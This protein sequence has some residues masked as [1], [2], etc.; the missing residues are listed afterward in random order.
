M[1][2]IAI[3]LHQRDDTFGQ[4]PYLLWP[5]LA[6]WQ[7][8][9]FRVLMLQG[10]QHAVPADLL[11][12]HLDLTVTPPDYAALYPRYPRVVNRPVLDIAKSAFSAQ[13]LR[14]GDAYD[15]PVIVK[16]DGN[17]GG[18]PDKHLGAGD[19]RPLASR[20]MKP[21]VKLRQR[22]G[23]ST[24]WRHLEHLPTGD[25]PVFQSLD[26]VPQGVFDNPRLVVE[27]FLAERDG[28]DYCLR[29]Y[30]FLGD[31]ESSLLLRSRNP[32]AKGANIDRVEPCPVPEELR[33][34][35]RRMGFD[36]GKFDYVLRDGR[37]VLF[38]V[39][40]TPTVT[41]LRRFGLYDAVSCHLAGGIDSLLGK[42]PART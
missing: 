16:T 41:V 31:R 30:S 37:V 24:P 19:P 2:T 39:N 13:L 1:Q 5:M 11:I 33:A 8:R 10:A 20:L 17:C 9:G 42:P 32:V 38:D 35:R 22:L 34:I 27:K 23:G 36:Y 28:A 6:L 12:P 4:Y 25:Y 21:L 3:L 7:A 14:Q 40:R 18:K 29:Y 15:G 26:Q